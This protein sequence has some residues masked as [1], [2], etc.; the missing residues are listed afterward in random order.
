M[1]ECKGCQYEFD[2]GGATLGDTQKRANAC[3]ECL[4]RE[5][6]KLKEGK[7]TVKLCPKCRK[8]FSAREG[9]TLIEVDSENECVLGDRMPPN[10]N[11][12]IEVIL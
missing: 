7:K 6:A 9:V 10:L 12:L 4:E 8:T 2:R 11:E 5:D 1:P 3:R